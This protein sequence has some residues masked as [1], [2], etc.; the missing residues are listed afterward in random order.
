MHDNVDE[1]E[2]EDASMDTPVAI[3]VHRTNALSAEY[4]Q[5]VMSSPTQT[6]EQFGAPLLPRTCIPPLV[7][8]HL[9][10]NTSSACCSAS[11]WGGISSRCV[12]RT[13]EGISMHQQS[14]PPTCASAAETPGR[15]SLAKKKTAAAKASEAL[16]CPMHC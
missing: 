12:C 9:P 10:G 1:W 7:R 8:L 3:H 11:A 6:E 13:S 16:K 4:Q 14:P 15:S 5:G 2:M